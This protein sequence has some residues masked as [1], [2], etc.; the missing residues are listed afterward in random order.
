MMGFNMVYKLME[1]KLKTCIKKHTNIFIM[2]KASK[3]NKII[4]LAGKINLIYLIGYSHGSMD[5][6]RIHLKITRY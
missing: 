4:C 6:F 1:T 5:K 2:K 3:M